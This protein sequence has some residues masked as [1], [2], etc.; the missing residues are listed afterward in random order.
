MEQNIAL[1]HVE[2]HVVAWQQ[3]K[4]P[5]VR[6][7]AGLQHQQRGVGPGHVFG[8]QVHRRDVVDVHA[9]CVPPRGA[10]PRARP[11]L[12][13]RQVALLPRR[14][15]RRAWMAFQQRP[16]GGGKLVQLRLLQG[17]K[18]RFGI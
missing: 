11:Q 18:R 8:V 9:E 13:A 4:A 12:A 17:G 3:V 16:R 7:V 14:R 1:P 5:R 15:R 6:L 2:R 10:Q